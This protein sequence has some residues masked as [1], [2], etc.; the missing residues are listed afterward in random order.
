[1][2]ELLAD[3]LQLVHSHTL[4]DVKHLEKGLVFK[5]QQLCRAISWL[6]QQSKNKSRNKNRNKKKPEENRKTKG[7]VTTAP[8][9]R[10]GSRF[11][12]C[13]DATLCP[14]HSQK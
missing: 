13:P 6:F 9:C 5:R 8:V 7:K 12:L 11:R 1:M 10:V 4:P 2:A 3:G 14:F